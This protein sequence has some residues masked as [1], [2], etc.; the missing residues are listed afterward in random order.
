MAAFI[1]GESPP[2]VKTAIFFISEAIKKIR[3]AKLG[4]LSQKMNAGDTLFRLHT[5]AISLS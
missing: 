4:N 5:L 2:E 1:P 3:I